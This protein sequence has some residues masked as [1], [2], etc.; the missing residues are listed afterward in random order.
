MVSIGL[1]IGELESGR[2]KLWLTI[3]YGVC[4]GRALS[5]HPIIEFPFRPAKLLT[6]LPLAASFHHVPSSHLQTTTFWT[7]ETISFRCKLSVAIYT[8]ASKAS[9]MAPEKDSSSVVQRLQNSESPIP[10]EKLP[11]ELQKLVDDE[12][13]LLDQIYDGT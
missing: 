3:M 13:T 7:S 2:M 4:S 6:F 11:D 12:E 9:A 5:L 10:R 1:D 8:K